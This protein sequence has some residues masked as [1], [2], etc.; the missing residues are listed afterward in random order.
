MQLAQRGRDAGI[1]GEIEGLVTDRRVALGA[2]RLPEVLKV[3][4]LGGAEVEL[5]D[6]K[7]RVGTLADAELGL[8]AGVA[9]V[10]DVAALGVDQ[11]GE[12][13]VEGQPHCSH[14]STQTAM[15]ARYASQNMP[16]TEK[17]LFICESP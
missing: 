4:R 9:R 10:A 17:L 7:R 11:P 15:A 16:H 1:D 3:D 13:L 5:L 2:E 6:V 8:A 14:A 12:G